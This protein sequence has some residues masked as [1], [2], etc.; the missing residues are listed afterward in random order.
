ML[1]P[2]GDEVSHAVEHGE[3]L[4]VGQ[5]QGGRGLIHRLHPCQ[6]AAIAGLAVDQILEGKHHVIHGH[7]FTVVPGEALICGKGGGNGI[8]VAA[9]LPARHEKGLN[10]A[11]LIGDY[12][13]SGDHRVVVEL[14]EDTVFRH[15]VGAVNGG[16]GTDAQ[17]LHIGNGGL[18][19]LHRFRRAAFGGSR[20]V[21]SRAAGCGQRKSAGQQ[22]GCQSFHTCSFFPSLKF[23][24]KTGT[25]PCFGLIM[26]EHSCFVVRKQ[27]CSLSWICKKGTAVPSDAQLMPQ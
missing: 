16:G 8:Q 18:A 22:K 23:L 14:A 7:R 4:A 9:Q 10:L 25:V 12:K 6:A 2:K 21:L 17:F 19:A 3:G 20:R 15:N 27:E 13:G 1:R 24:F 11:I 5:R 26:K